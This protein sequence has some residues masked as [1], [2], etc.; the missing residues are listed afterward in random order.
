MPSLLFDEFE[1]ALDETGELP[2]NFIENEE[3]ELTNNGNINRGIVLRNGAFF[4]DS[5]VIRD[6]ATGLPLQRSQ[7]LFGLFNATVSGKIHKQVASAIVITDSNVSSTVFVDYQ[8]LGG[9]WGASNAKVI[10]MYNKLATDNRPVHW[11]DIIGKPDG[12]KPAHHLQDI[13]DMYG[14]EYLVAPIERLTDAIL[15]GD[16]ASHDEIF[17]LIDEINNRFT[18]AVDNLRTELIARMDAGDALLLARII[19]TETNLQA[20]I[21]ALNTDLRGLIQNVSDRLTAHEAQRNPHGTTAAD[22]GAPTVAQMTLAINNLRDE[23][24]TMFETPVIAVP[25]GTTLR[26]NTHRNAI[27][28]ITG[29]GSIFLPAG[30]FQ[31]GDKI[32]I[33]TDVGSV[34]ISPAGGMSITVPSGKRATIHQSG[35]LGAITILT[36][37][38][39]N[40]AGYLQNL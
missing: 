19:Q 5:V 38:L 8:C 23:M 24:I 29:A 10:E 35:A 14:V 30:E 7:Y 6:G 33:H 37:N 28:K 34:T 17:R 39:A 3:R 22:T 31:A 16:N 27:C 40:V 9:P 21:D 18:D 11:P 1:Y 26:R 2:A 13:G 25:I 20:A 36:P 32:L 4:T 12:Y 15:M